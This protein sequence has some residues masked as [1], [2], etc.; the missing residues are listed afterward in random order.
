MACLIAC[1]KVS[2]Y[3]LTWQGQRDK[4]VLMNSTPELSTAP[5][6]NREHFVTRQRTLANQRE[7]L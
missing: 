1:R 7:W 2:N 3:T 5:C 4:Y 6:T